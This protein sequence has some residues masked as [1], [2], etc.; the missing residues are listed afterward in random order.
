MVKSLFQWFQ[1]FQSNFWVRRVIDKQTGLQM[2]LL[3]RFDR[4][5][6]RFY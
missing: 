3:E 4:L 5:E 1:P 6:Q 2:K